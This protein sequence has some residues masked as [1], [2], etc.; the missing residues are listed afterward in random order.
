MA[1]RDGGDRHMASTE[2]RLSPVGPTVHGQRLDGAVGAWGIRTRRRESGLAGRAL[3]AANAIGAWGP[4]GGFHRPVDEG[5]RT[6][7]A[8]G[9][10]CRSPVVR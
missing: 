8:F 6:F 10:E 9:R 2:R 5:A 1:E 4:R 3:R 7:L